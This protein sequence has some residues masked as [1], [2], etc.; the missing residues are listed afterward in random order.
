MPPTT[1]FAGRAILSL[2]DLAVAV[3]ALWWHVPTPSVVQPLDLIRTVER[4]NRPVSAFTVGS[5][6]TQ[7]NG[8]PFP[9]V[10]QGNGYGFYANFSNL[11]P[12]R[13]CDCFRSYSCEATVSLGK[14][15]F[16]T[17]KCSLCE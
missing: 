10:N 2:F 8:K 5:E 13:K 9:A 6:Q 12:S 3:V 17:L 14:N 11:S 4:M 16:F 1:T 15:D 7:S